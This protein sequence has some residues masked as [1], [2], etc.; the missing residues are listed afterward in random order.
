MLIASSDAFAKLIPDYE[1]YPDEAIIRIEC[2]V[3]ELRGL[4]A[5]KAAQPEPMSDERMRKAL[6]RAFLLGQ[7]YWQQADSESYKQNKLAAGTQEQF[8]ALV[9]ETCA[10]LSAQ[11]NGWVSVPREATREME[12]AADTFANERA[13]TPKGFWYWGALYRAMLAAAPKEAK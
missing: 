3:R 4:A 5:I 7:T 2:S 1:G 13:G 11:P 10:L 8:N 6:I 9:E 12:F